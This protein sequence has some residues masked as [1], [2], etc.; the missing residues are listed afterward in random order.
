[1]REDIKKSF[2]ECQMSRTPYQLERF[3]VGQHDTAEMQFVQVCREIEGL[4]YALKHLEI[5]IKKS[6]IEIE[7]FRK[8]EDE[9][10]QL[11]ADDM[12]LGLERTML[13]AT[14][15][16]QEFDY[17]IEMYDQMPHFSREQID[18]SQPSYW[19][20]RL[21]RQASYQVSAGGVNWSHLE[22]LD[23]VGLLQL[24]S[25][26]NEQMIGVAEQT[27]GELRK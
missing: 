13:V 17:L 22:A 12:E 24:N 1:M 25:Q 8:S 26:S 27:I 11:Q 23:Q 10:E 14:G 16:K 6:K 2:V 7:R 9:L 19:Q 3:V 20:S 5:N 18:S 4:Y 21:G 15:T